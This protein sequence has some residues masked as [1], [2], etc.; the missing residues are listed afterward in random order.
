MMKTTFIL[1]ALL[2]LL[3]AL[4]TLLLEVPGPAGLRRS[5][6]VSER[7]GYY[8]PVTV[9]MGKL[10]YCCL[11]FARGIHKAWPGT[12]VGWHDPGGRPGMLWW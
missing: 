9:T 7:M 12:V 8:Q 1:G 11:T 10:G 6:A 4:L 2:Q 5:S 3:G